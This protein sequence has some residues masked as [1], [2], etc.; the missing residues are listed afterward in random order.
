MTDFIYYTATTTDYLGNEVFITGQ[1]HSPFLNFFL[2]FLVL[3]F[4]LLV[5]QFFYKLLYIPR[6]P[7]MELKNKVY[8][9]KK[10]LLNFFD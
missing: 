4:S 2:V 5:V 8:L 6:E 9:S 7:K 1:Y 3:L 10:G